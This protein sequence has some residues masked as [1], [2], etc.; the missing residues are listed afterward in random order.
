MLYIKNGIYSIRIDFK[1]LWG[2][3]MLNNTIWLIV[4]VYNAEN[5]LTKC[6]RSIQKQTYKKW[7]L[8]LVDDGSKDS[9]GKL[10][11]KFAKKDSRIIVVH[12]ANAGPSA[13]RKTGVAQ[14]PDDGYCAFCDSDDW[15]PRNALELMMNET[16]EHNVD[17]VCGKMV[18]TYKNIHLPNAMS[19]KCF[20]AP[21]VYEKKEMM[22]Q[23]FS[24]CLG[25][26]SDFPVSLCGK[27]FKIPKIKPIILDSCV[28][29]KKFAEDLDVMMRSMPSFDRC[30]I[31]TDCVY[32]YRKGG[33][34][35]GFM[36]EYLSDSL[37]L[38]N[39]KKDYLAHY[40]GE[41]DVKGAISS[42]LLTNS[43]TYLTVC[44]RFERYSSGSLKAEIGYVCS[45]PEI[46]EAL[47]IKGSE[48]L[49]WS[50]PGA[51][52]CMRNYDSAGLEKIVVDYVEMIRQRTLI[53]KIVGVLKK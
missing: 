20:S 12:Q 49:K 34:T 40:T 10:C 38:Y 9:S 48:N 53:K 45:L 15:M 27:I 6:V 46:Q 42:E 35:S 44:K 1:F 47:N 16:I 11:D 33:G 51:W 32:Y 28:V 23:L 22:S 19:F 26:G 24:A 3:V 4:P 17:M 30:S 7:K 39:R 29:P 2:M 50:Y 31:I 41:S 5:T 37:F 8:V 18:V 36:P 21:K 13:A 14:I 43:I 52:E 25:Y